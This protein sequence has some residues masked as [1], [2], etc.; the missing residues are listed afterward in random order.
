[1]ALTRYTRIK[2][3]KPNGFWLVSFD[4]QRAGT[5][6]PA[7]RNSDNRQVYPLP[8]KSQARIRGGFGSSAN[9]A[10]QMDLYSV[11]SDRIRVLSFDQCNWGLLRMNDGVVTDRY[12]IHGD[13]R[14]ARDQDER[15]RGP[16]LG[17]DG[18]L[19]RI[20]PQGRPWGQSGQGYV[21]AVD[22]EDRSSTR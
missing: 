2:T 4:C 9:V 18:N 17:T 15:R 10:K 12:I 20:V 14:E 5:P 8:K 6:R 19:E 3:I 11:R 7:G 21:D 13:L 1:M 16:E 22:A